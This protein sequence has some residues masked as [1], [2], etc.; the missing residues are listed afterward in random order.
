M[1]LLNRTVLAIRILAFVGSS[2]SPLVKVREISD[3]LSIPPQYAAKLAHILTNGGF[4]SAVRGP[5][6]GVRLARPAED[7]RIGQIVEVLEDIGPSGADGR[8]GVGAD[9]EPEIGRF[10]DQALT[11]FLELLNAQSLA[12][13]CVSRNCALGGSVSELARWDRAEKKL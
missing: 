13:L 11:K 6:G 7:I 1:L 3:E 2:P 10:L 5:S 12:D 4:L 9:A 8:L